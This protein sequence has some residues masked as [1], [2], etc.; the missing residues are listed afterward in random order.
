MSTPFDGTWKDREEKEIAVASD[1]DILTVKY[2][3]GRGHFTGFAGDIGTPV[4]YVNFTDHDGFSGVLSVASKV[5][6]E[7]RKKIFW[8][9]GTVWTRQP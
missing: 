2:A 1:G 3:G 4:I 6:P 5:V 9:N 7:E 8:S